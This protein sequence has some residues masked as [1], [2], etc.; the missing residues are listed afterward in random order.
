MQAMVIPVIL[1]MRLTQKYTKDN[2]ERADARIALTNEVFSGIRVIKLNGWVEAFDA[3][4][5]ALRRA[6]MKVLRKLVFMQQVVSGTLF[7]TIAPVLPIVI[8]SAAHS[9][10]TTVKAATAFSTLSLLNAVLKWMGPFWMAIFERI[11]ARVAM[12]RIQDILLLPE[13]PAEAMQAPDKPGVAIQISG[14][15]FSWSDDAAPTLT[16]IDL[17]VKEGELL[18]IV[19]PVACGKS[20]LL[21]AIQGEIP[22]SPGSVRRRGTMSYVAQ[23]PWIVNATLRENILFGI[24][25]EEERY[26]AIL[27]ATALQPDLRAIHGGDRAEIGEK[28]IN[29]SGG[30][31]ARVELARALYTDRDVILLDD[32]LSAVDNQAGAHIMKE[33]VLGQLAGKTRVLCTHALQYLKDCD[34]VVVMHGGKITHVGSYDELVAA[35]VDFD[36]EIASES[37]APAA[38]SQSQASEPATTQPDEDPSALIVD[39]H[40]DVG[41]VRAERYKAYFSRMG[42]WAAGIW[43]GCTIVSALV[44]TVGRFVL[45]RWSDL[46]TCVGPAWSNTS[47]GSWWS[48]CLER[49]R[50][51]GPDSWGPDDDCCAPAGSADC[52][53]GLQFA[54]D[55][56]DVCWEHD[57]KPWAF[58]TVCRPSCAVGAHQAACCV[59]NSSNATTMCPDGF[60][61]DSETPC[62]GGPHC[63]NSTCTAMEEDSD[64]AI[65]LYKLTGWVLL[66]VMFVGGIAASIGRLQA[67]QTLHREMVTSVLRARVVEF[68]DATPLGRIVNRFSSDM[69]ELDTHLPGA[70]GGFV[71][72]IGGVVSKATSIAVAT[73]GVCILALIPMAALYNRFARYFR[74]AA[75]ELKRLQSLAKSPTTSAFTE[76]L[77]GATS[78]RG[79]G[80]S[81]D[82]IAKS[83]ARFTALTNVQ[84]A[85]GFANLWLQVRMQA[86]SCV[87]SGLVAAYG[88]A[89][90][91]TPFAVSP[92]WIGLALLASF[93]FPTLLMFLVMAFAAAEQAMNSVE[94]ITEYIKDLPLEAAADTATL[95]PDGAWPARG[96]LRVEGLSM[97][98]KEGLPLVLDKVSFQVGAGQHC[99]IVGRTG[100]GKSSIMQ[101]IFRTVEFENGIIYIDD[102]DTKQ[103]P[104][105]VL[106]SRLAIISQDPVIY[107][108]SVR[109][110]LDPTSSFSDE[111]VWAALERCLMQG[112]VEALPQKL[113]TAVAERGE[114]FSVGQRQLLC[115]ARALLRE[116]KLLC[117]DEA[118][119]SI[120]NDSDAEVQEMIRSVFANTTTLTIAHRLNT[121]LDGDLVMVMRAGQVAECGPPQEL[122]A[123]PQSALS[124]LARANK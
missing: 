94:R 92:S 81:A 14:A 19:G 21:A 86:M 90:R 71:A 101:A 16:E 7:G 69:E 31:K 73:F 70:L 74:R 26:Q 113:A 20:T 59:G 122:L 47:S 60:V 103:I 100:S 118:T 110:N 34:R 2:L 10:H 5:D 28:G 61:A 117:M 68:Y 98:Y 62:S 111:Q 8:F 32:V 3:Q 93:E 35:G 36:R 56:D 37:S 44:P 65:G 63:T 13:L 29:L 27:A 67:S 43:L 75:I 82:F 88:I 4:I 87:I 45:A 85:R 95:T 38:E 119:A 106:R 97:R 50:G 30:Q 24:Q 124:A 57:G 54:Q 11:R 105:E 39:E 18:A 55:L 9:R 42:H 40:R 6:Q 91:G 72:S 99:G 1:V 25:E 121:V 78:I 46:P 17:E 96:E 15:N 76:T 23:E 107:S 48:G 66:G 123:D 89:T 41:M 58:R 102:V 84:V 33:A 112:A 108:T 77:A 49:G 115:I 22:A 83:D 51:D 114:S 79:Y 104:L 80:A 64:Q 53:A 52:V 116:P 12:R 120:D 109:E